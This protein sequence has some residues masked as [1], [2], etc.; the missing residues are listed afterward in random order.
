MKR[1]TVSIVSALRGSGRPHHRG[2]PLAGGHRPRRGA[3]A[4]AAATVTWSARWG[5]KGDIPVANDYG[6][7][8]YADLAVF[9][10]SDG[11]WYIRGWGTTGGAS[12]E[13]SRRRG[14]TPTTAG[15]TSRCT[16]RATGTGTSAVSAATSGG[17][18]ATSP[19]RRTTTATAMPTSPCTASNGYWY[20]RG[21][22]NYPW[23]LSK[24]IPVP[25]DYNGDRRVDIAVFRPSNGGWYIRG[26]GNYTWG[27]SGD[28]PVASD[29]TVMGRAD[30]AVFRPSN[31]YW[32]VRAGRPSSGAWLATSRNRATSVVMVARTAWCGAQYRCLVGAH[33]G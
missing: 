26:V 16:G 17:S 7:D 27:L 11:Y 21:I 4:E 18:R 15:S 14:T 28:I 10:P 30:L 3:T 1:I 12:R 23:G 33:V 2:C 13:T 9:R 24:D 19:C 32:Y 8:K 6:G 31:G 22:G 20:I 25:R 5:L 29:Y